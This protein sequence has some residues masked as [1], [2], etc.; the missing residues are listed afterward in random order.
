MGL[1]LVDKQDRP[2][3][4]GWFFDGEV[5]KVA[6]FLRQERWGISARQAQFFDPGIAKLSGGRSQ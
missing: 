1:P 6:K 5:W 3:L 4:S 2:R